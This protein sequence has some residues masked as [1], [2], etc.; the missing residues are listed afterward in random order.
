MKGLEEPRS[1]TQRPFKT[2]KSF[3]RWAPFKP[4]PLVLPRVAGGGWLNVLNYFNGL[5]EFIGVNY[6]KAADKKIAR[7]VQ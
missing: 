6:G 7:D 2:F 1:K 4:P 5:N 3:N